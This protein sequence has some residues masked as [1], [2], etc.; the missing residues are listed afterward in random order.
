MKALNLNIIPILIKE[1][2]KCRQSIMKFK[3][4]KKIDWILYKGPVKILKYEV[5]DYNVNKVYPSDHK[6]IYV[7]VEINNK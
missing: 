6:P 3:D 5:V 7:E 2:Q 1:Q 4:P